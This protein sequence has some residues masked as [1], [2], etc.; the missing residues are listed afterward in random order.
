MAPR[1]ITQGKIKSIKKSLIREYRMQC[2]MFLCVPMSADILH[3]LSNTELRILI[4]TA[5]KN[6]EKITLNIHQLNAREAFLIKR[7]K[8]DNIELD[9]IKYQ[10]GDK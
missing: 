3:G 9:T 7:I 8:A 2:A 1:R 6:R 10:L 4:E 5:D